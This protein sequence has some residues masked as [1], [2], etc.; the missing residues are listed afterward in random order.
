MPVARLTT[1]LVATACALAA[2][3]GQAAPAD[4]QRTA[5]WFKAHQ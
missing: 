2:I 3:P 1:L 4:S 5:S